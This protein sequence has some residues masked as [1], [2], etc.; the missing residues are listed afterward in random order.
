MKNKFI[1]EKL[2]RE[3]NNKSVIEGFQKNENIAI[4]FENVKPESVFR[5]TFIKGLKTFQ[6]QQKKFL[7][8]FR[9]LKE[10]C[11]IFGTLSI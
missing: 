1:V 7:K 10:L 5:S 2:P 6:I 11:D 4:C 9:V 8:C 3:K